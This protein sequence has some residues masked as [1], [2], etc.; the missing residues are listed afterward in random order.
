M[1]DEKSGLS[2]TAFDDETP[3]WVHNIAKRGWLRT[4]VRISGIQSALESSWP[5]A[6]TILLRC[7]VGLPSLAGLPMAVISLPYF[8]V[9]LFQP[10]LD[11]MAK[12]PNSMLHFSTAPRSFFTSI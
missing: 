8:S 3:D 10:A 11:N 5:L 12:A 9:S 1:N 2:H 4:Y 7:I 6:K